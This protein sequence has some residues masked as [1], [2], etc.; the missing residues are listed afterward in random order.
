MDECRQK[1]EW[2]GTHCNQ[3][4]T[5][6]IAASSAPAEKSGALRTASRPHILRVPVTSKRRINLKAL[7]PERQTGPSTV[8]NVQ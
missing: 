8:I 2:T 6:R 5:T 3:Q 7:P 4:Q 1:A